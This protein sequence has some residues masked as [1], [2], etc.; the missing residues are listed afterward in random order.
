MLNCA[1][2]KFETSETIQHY[3][4]PVMTGGL[5]TTL[6]FSFHSIKK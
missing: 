2:I 1:E 5:G 4:I 3:K 6:R